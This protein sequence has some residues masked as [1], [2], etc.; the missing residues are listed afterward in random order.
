MLIDIHTTHFEVRCRA[1]A[2][3]IKCPI[4]FFCFVIVKC[5]F[6]STKEHFEKS[7]K[8]LAKEHVRCSQTQTSYLVVTVPMRGVF[9]PLTVDCH[10][11]SG[12]SLIHRSARE[13]KQEDRDT[14]ECVVHL[15]RNRAGK[16]KSWRHRKMKKT[17]KQPQKHTTVKAI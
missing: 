12:C 14:R 5:V 16:R 7:T 10:L 8:H 3:S 6:E 17:K 2:R 15:K 4:M 1:T 13:T 11:F 9:Y